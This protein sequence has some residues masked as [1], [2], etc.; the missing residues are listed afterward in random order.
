LT[1]LASE[2]SVLG[3]VIG[4]LGSIIGLIGVFD[5]I[6]SFGKVSAEVLADGLKYPY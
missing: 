6:E 3:L 2:V 4:F 5:S 1:K